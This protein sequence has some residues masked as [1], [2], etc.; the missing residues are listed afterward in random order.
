MKNKLT[1]C[2]PL[3]QIPFISQGDHEDD[4]QHLKHPRKLEDKFLDEYLQSVE[5]RR[6][7]AALKDGPLALA[8]LDL[9][10]PEPL[11]T[12]SEPTTE[13]VSTLKNDAKPLIKVTQFGNVSYLPKDFRRL[14]QSETRYIKELLNG[15]QG[16][17]NIARYNT[18]FSK[19]SA[20]K[21]GR[22]GD[23]FYLS[24][25]TNPWDS[26]LKVTVD[27]SISSLMVLPM[28]EARRWASWNDFQ[29]S[30]EEKP[31]PNRGLYNE[32]LNKFIASGETLVE[33]TVRDKGAGYIKRMLKTKIEEMGKAHQIEASRVDDWVYLEKLV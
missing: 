30:I 8:L 15:V 27:S 28:V 24:S 1:P 17:G 6:E 10:Q 12:Q 33:I 2:F 11:K 7:K 31:L 18:V 20:V 23:V 4:H 16:L 21:N 26:V 32:I 19:F 29:D 25:G 22:Y 5:E 13:L 9:P 14:T 3:K